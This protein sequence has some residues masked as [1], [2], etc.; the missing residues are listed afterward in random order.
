MNCVLCSIDASTCSTGISIFLNGKYLSSS[1]LQF[2]DKSAPERFKKMCLAILSCLDS[3]SPTVIYM[4]EA[5]VV[6]NAQTQRALIRLQGVVYGWAIQ[7]SAECN[8]IRPTEWRAHAGIHSG[9]KKRDVLKLEA[10]NVVKEKLNIDTNDDV[11]ESILIG[12]AA[13]NK[14]NKE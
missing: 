14:Y 4:E 13:I 1:L 10:V 7:H 6:R 12:I 9:K 8:F 11:A 2:S 5:A 3:A